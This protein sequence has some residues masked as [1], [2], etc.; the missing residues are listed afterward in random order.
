LSGQRWRIRLG[1]EAEK[2]FER[3]LAYTRDTYGEQQAK[4][5]QMTLID[6]IAAF[7]DGPD[8]RGSIA[9]D[10]ILP[11]LR[12]LHVARNG[13]RGRHVVLYRAGAGRAIDVIR[14][15]HDAMD[16]ARHIP[17]ESE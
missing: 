11:N 8:V 1:V 9:R 7:A 12:T 17:R 5:Y 15:L 4:T 16:F 10:E 13:R 3:I 6:A 2:D 14:I